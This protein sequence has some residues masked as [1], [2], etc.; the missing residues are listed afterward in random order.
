MAELSPDVEKKVQEIE[1]RK[2]ALQEQ[3]ISLKAEV[4]KLDNELLN[5]GATSHRVSLTMRW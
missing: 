1:A 5:A 4:L 3:I 2:M